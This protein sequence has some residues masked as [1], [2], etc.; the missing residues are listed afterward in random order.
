MIQLTYALLL[1]AVAAAPGD[2]VLV[3]FSSQQC[4][5]CRAMQP[6]VAQLEQAGVPVRRVDVQ[7]EP[8]LVSRFGVRQTP[9]FVVLKSGVEQTRLVG[10]QSYQQLWS[11]LTAD[12]TQLTPTGSVVPATSTA[13]APPMRLAPYRQP[14]AEG[15]AAANDTANGSAGEP[16]PSMSMAMA[17]ERA[18][19]ATVRLRV[20]DDQGYG[21]GTG[22]IIDMHGEEALVLTCGHLFRDTGGQGRIE[23]DVFHGGQVHTV[24]GQVID[25]DA[26]D[27]DIALVVIKPG[28]PVQ[29]VPV[30]QTGQTV[31]PGQT[32]FS[33]GCDRGND[34]SRRD[35]RITGV[36]K[37]NQ[38]IGA[39]NL[40]IDGA[41]ID[42]RSGG[43]LFDES[44]RLIG[45]CNAADY[46]A[47]VGI[48]AGP[49]AIGW[50]LDRV[51]LARLHK[52]DPYAD[53]AAAPA[54]PPA[55][56]PA[57]SALALASADPGTD[58]A[59]STR[60]WP[61]PSTTASGNA[62]GPVD[63]AEV[64]V[65]VRQGGQSRMVTFDTPPAEL[66][67]LLEAQPQ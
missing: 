4:P 10:A 22:T 48:Y 42:G 53:V 66:Q 7:Q 15:A 47:D 16:M 13:D 5:P 34:P 64:I 39:S 52:E 62:A 30:I 28:L 40:E 17:V 38:H 23:V 63:D 41:P 49:G 50:Q 59:A 29:P 58:A 12:D 46:D 18:E 32:A 19:A 9:T 57:D 43:G 61:I 44:G 67:R 54:A 11:S 2:A 35:T 60:P 20:H 21:A 25:F 51:D 27:R 26:K 56:G 14:A 65:I 36:N 6:V 37:Y 31:R 55:A 3:E 24:A 1:S 45:V 8:A 33:F